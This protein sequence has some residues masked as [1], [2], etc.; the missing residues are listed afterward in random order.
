[1]REYTDQDNRKDFGLPSHVDFYPSPK[2]SSH[3]YQPPM[4]DQPN[5][6][7]K[8]N[9]RNFRISSSRVK[10]RSALAQLTLKEESDNKSLVVDCA[11]GNNYSLQP[12]SDNILDC[13][14]N[15]S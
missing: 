14:N 5:D 3:R 13:D 2:E 4:R 1:M 11:I 8:Y 6:F 10:S 12:N 15:N 7:R 9:Q